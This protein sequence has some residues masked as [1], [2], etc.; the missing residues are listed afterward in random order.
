M[1]ANYEPI[2][3]L[4]EDEVRLNYIRA[5]YFIFN[6]KETQLFKDSDKRFIYL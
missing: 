4:S 1:A 6:L 2:Y 5:Y 3:G